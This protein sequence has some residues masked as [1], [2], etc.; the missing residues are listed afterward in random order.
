MKIQKKGFT[1][2]EVLVVVAII[3]VMSAVVLAMVSPSRV[4]KELENQSRILSTDI[5]ALQ[6]SVLTGAVPPSFPEETVLC[7]M[8]VHRSDD[9]YTL[10]AITRDDA[11]SVTSNGCRGTYSRTF[12][13]PTTL[14]QEKSMKAGVT[15]S[16]VDDMYFEAPNAIMYKGGGITNDTLEYSLEKDSY[17]YHVCVEGGI[18]VKEQ[19]S[20]SC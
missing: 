18:R 16:N 2:I 10:Y 8:G 12:S 6:R 3:A 9:G 17:T 1:L 13:G 7:G 15:M 4:K 19:Y 20:N 5:R 11:D 14:I